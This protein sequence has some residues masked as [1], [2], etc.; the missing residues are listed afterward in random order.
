MSAMLYTIDSHTYVSPNYSTRP[1]GTAVSAIVLHTT[2]GSFDS[3][4]EWL[5]NPTTGVSCHYVIP[6][7]GSTIYSLV[8]DSKRAWH[9]GDSTYNG[10][11]NWNTFSIGIEISHKKGQPYPNGQRNLT[12]ELCIDLIARYHIGQE[13]IA[14]HR[15]VATPSGRKSDPTDWNDT[16]LKSWISAL[17]PPPFIRYEVTSPCA[18]F[19]SR[20]PDAPLSGGPNEGQT[21]LDAGDLINVGD[22][23]DGWLWVSDNETN[24]P[25][26]GFIPSS[27]ARVL[28]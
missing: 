24:P 23:Q 22:V 2:E 20:A 25:G 3:D 28:P 7:S 12:A 14:A 11:S 26:I 16:D 5:C 27:Y 4:A 8:P 21:W 6:P 1:S 17:Y 15:W 19:T 18:V 13:W 10:R 9:A